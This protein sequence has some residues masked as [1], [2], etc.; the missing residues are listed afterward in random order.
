[1]KYI[2]L[3]RSDRYIDA[4]GARYTLYGIDVWRIPDRD[5]RLHKSYPD[6]FT[7]SIDAENLA[8]TLTEIDPT[9][10]IVSRI[11]EETRERSHRP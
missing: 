3:P 5:A 9:P 7:H 2:Y 1:M 8:K 10:E 4:N 6:L 11:I